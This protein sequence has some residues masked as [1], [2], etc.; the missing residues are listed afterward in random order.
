V[1]ATSV[2]AR[3]IPPG[4]RSELIEAAWTH[5]YR[6]E[7]GVAD[8][9]LY[10][11]SD[12]NVPGEIG[13]AVD[14]AG[15]AWFLA[16][17]H[18]GVAAELNAPAAEPAPRG[19][20]A[21]FGFSDRSELRRA[22]HRTYDLACSLPT[23]PLYE[24][25][26]EVAGLGETETERMT[27]LRVGQPIFRRAL[28]LYWKGRCPLTGIEEPELLRASHI[29]SWA[30]CASDAQRLDVHNGLLLAAHWDAAFDS[31]LVTFSDEGRPILRAEVGE[32][33]I[34][35]LRADQV[36]T[37]SLTEDHRRHLAWHRARHGF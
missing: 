34:S 26:A 30:E 7:T 5:G 35:A 27:K 10:F 21:A 31:G 32:A 3:S 2:R 24:Y 36:P 8:G 11:G 28:M 4:L 19:M 16:I 1:L 13:L 37:M 15:A 14:E 29:V 25:L 18:A 33:A 9:W 17:G 20:C 6:R 22:L 23:V 12:I